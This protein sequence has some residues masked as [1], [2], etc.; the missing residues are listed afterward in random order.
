MAAT[1]MNAVG[2]AK[3]N[4]QYRMMLSSL[5]SALRIRCATSKSAISRRTAGSSRQAPRLACRG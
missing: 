4:A 5:L 1:D 3:R 2:R